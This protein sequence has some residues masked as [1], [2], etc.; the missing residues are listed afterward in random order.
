MPRTNPECIGPDSS[1]RSL[2]GDILLLREE[3]DEEEDKE[4]RDGG[5][6]EDDGDRGYSHLF[7]AWGLAFGG[8]LLNEASRSI[9]GE[10]HIWT[11]LFL[12]PIAS[13]AGWRPTTPA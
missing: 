7:E 3:P 6:E 2:S 1:D 8:N 9:L 12:T 10:C 13:V 5:E 4:E 11:S